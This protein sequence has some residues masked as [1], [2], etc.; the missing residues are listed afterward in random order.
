MMYDSPEDNIDQRLCLLPNYFGF[1]Y[2]S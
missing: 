1:C 2:I